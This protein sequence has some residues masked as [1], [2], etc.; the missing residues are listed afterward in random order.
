MPDDTPPRRACDR[1]HNIK[2]RCQWT[3]GSDTCQRCLRL[4]HECQTVRPVQKLGRK[5]RSRT[6]RTIPL[7]GSST[8]QPPGS[9]NNDSPEGGQSTTDRSEGSFASPADTYPHRPAAEDITKIF[10][11]VPGLDDAERELLTVCFAKSDACGQFTLGPSFHSRHQHDLCYRLR[12]AVPELK[13]G[14]I[15]CAVIMARH[16]NLLVSPSAVDACARKAAVGVASLR[17][18]QVKRREDV[19]ICLVLGMVTCTYSLFAANGQTQTIS[20]CTLS[21]IRPWYRSSNVL[22]EVDEYAYLISLMYTEMID[23]VLRSEIPTLKYG[24]FGKYA[25]WV[26]RYLGLSP[27]FLTFLYEICELSAA[28]RSSRNVNGAVHQRISEIESNIRQWK[29]TETNDFPH[30]Y[31]PIEAM[32]IMTQIRTLRQA[33][34][35]LLHRLQYPYG[36]EDEKGL[37]I[38]DSIL[39]ECNLVVQYVPGVPMGM[40][41]PFV[42]ACFESKGLSQQEETL[43][44]V[45]RQLK[46]AEGFQAKIRIMLKHVWRAKAMR[47]NLYWFDLANF[48]DLPPRSPF[49]TAS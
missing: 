32:Q 13:D 3:P 21:L 48:I 47:P 2:E 46:F 4:G 41:I 7:Y 6:L 45:A 29:P 11:G 27:P 49:D 9:L 43:Q 37:A 33:T 18:V 23:C 38:A 8:S 16:Q 19:T 20:A 39:L 12:A 1:C 5:P 34:L 15:S 10:D 28:L 36:V 44:A 24:D 42:V 35:L 40:E 26:D 30:R 14:F 31:T 22:L 17:Q 25:T